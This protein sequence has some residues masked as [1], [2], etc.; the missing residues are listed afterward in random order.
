MLIEKYNNNHDLLIEEACLE[1][2]KKLKKEE[3]G[4]VDLMKSKSRDKFKE[5]EKLKEKLKEK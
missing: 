5:K 3:N 1:I 2:K 4:V